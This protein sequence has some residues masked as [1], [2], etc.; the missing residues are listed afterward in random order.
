M[1]I[2]GTFATLQFP[3]LKNKRHVLPQHVKGSL[4]EFKPAKS[5]SK[6]ISCHSIL[7]SG[8]A[9]RQGHDPHG[10]AL[11]EANVG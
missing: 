1:G 11:S 7:P 10:L 5:L 8:E 2:P 6:A 9:D 4:S 3:S